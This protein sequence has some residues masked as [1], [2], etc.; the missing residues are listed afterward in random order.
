MGLFSSSLRRSGVRKWDWLTCVPHTHNHKFCKLHN[1]SNK[2]H[3]LDDVCN[4]IH[5]HTYTHIHTH[6]HTHIH[7]HTSKFDCGESW[8]MAMPLIN[9]Q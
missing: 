1:E 8:S 6:T 9:P 4:K 2:L 5:T 7:T 3:H